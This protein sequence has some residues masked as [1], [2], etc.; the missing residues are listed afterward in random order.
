MDIYR[1]SK[2]GDTLDFIELKEVEFNYQKGKNVF[3]GLNLTF[4]KGETT[5]IVGPN[6]S[7]KTTL[8]KLMAGILKP[9]KGQVFIQKKSTFQLTLP[10]IG[11]KI[12][13]LFQNPEKQFF[14]NTVYDELSFILKL[15]SY[16]EKHIEEMVEKHLKLFQ[17]KGLEDSSPFILSQ[18]EKQRLAIGAVLINQ[19]EYLILDE[20]TTGLDKR[21]KDTLLNILLKLKE[22]GIGMTIIGHDYPF[23]KSISNRI[24]A[25]NRGEIEYDKR[26]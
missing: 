2:A 26:L 7:G 8:G 3:K 20:P 22:R 15:K 6:G 25:I 9:D 13:Y 16:E 14:A 19:P 24:I 5:A 21:R 1:T 12:G 11:R 17:L 23:V 4:Q 10:E 18:G